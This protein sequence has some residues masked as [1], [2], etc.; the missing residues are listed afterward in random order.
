MAERST[1]WTGSGGTGE[2]NRPHSYNTLPSTEIASCFT[3]AT[4]RSRTQRHT[5][6]ASNL[7][8][9]FLFPP[10]A[11]CC[12]WL[13]ICLQEIMFWRLLNLHK[14]TVLLCTKKGEKKPIQ[15]KS[16]PALQMF[17]L[18]NMLAMH[19]KFPWKVIVYTSDIPTTSASILSLN[20]VYTCEQ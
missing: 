4:L 9:I 11:Y 2:S 8:Y 10:P 3:Q 19:A 14:H 6:K 17:S 7:Q 20:V 13:G 12:L 5:N 18:H 15:E 1:A 16:W